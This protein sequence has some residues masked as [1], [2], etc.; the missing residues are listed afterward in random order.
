MPSKKFHE[1]ASSSMRVYLINGRPI[2]HLIGDSGNELERSYM[3]YKYPCHC[4]MRPKSFVISIHETGARVF[5]KD[6]MP[7]FT[8]TEAKH[9]AEALLKYYDL[10]NYSNLEGVFDAYRAYKDFYQC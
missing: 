9:L 8:S 4:R 5:L 6:M 3:T 7:N 2:L 1:W 10:K